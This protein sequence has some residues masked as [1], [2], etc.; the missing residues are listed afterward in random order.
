MTSQTK[1]SSESQSKSPT[2]DLSPAICGDW[3]GKLNGYE[4]RLWN[5]MHSCSRLTLKA[6]DCIAR[7]P[8]G[9]LVFHDVTYIEMPLSTGKVKIREANNEEYARVRERIGANVQAST[10][11]ALQA[12]GHRVFL[13]EFG[14]AQWLHDHAS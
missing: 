7:R 4:F 13:I 2:E 5:Y 9:L 8:S 1:A 10:V 6:D 12:T 11:L 3:I 14:F